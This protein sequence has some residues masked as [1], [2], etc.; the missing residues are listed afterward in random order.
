LS[1]FGSRRRFPGRSA[2]ASFMTA[3]QKAGTGASFAAGGG[4]RGEF[5]SPARVC[6]VGRPSV[7]RSGENG[8]G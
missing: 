5:L 6:G 3:C 8:P 1:G 2:S 7:I 4:G